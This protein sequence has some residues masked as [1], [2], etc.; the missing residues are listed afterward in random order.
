MTNQPEKAQANGETTRSSSLSLLFDIRMIIAAL[1]GV[2]G[3]LL[4]V[5]GLAPGLAELG[6]R[7]I[8]HTPDRA[9]MAVGSA[10]NLWVGGALVLVAAGF[11]AWAL[12]GSRRAGS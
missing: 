3:V 10:G 9:D 2:Y 4:L 11:A 5:A 6:A 7:E 1:L 8:A 12:I